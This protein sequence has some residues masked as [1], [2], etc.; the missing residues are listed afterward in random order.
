[1]ARINLSNGSKSYWF[2]ADEAGAAIAFA[3]DN[4]ISLAAIAAAMNDDTREMVSFNFSPCSDTEFLGMY[5]KCADT[6]M[7][8]G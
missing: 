4:G 8:V 5:L 2:T 3:E 6:D 7:I 1:M